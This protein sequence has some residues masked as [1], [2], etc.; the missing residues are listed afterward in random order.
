M[1]MSILAEPFGDT[2]FDTLI[3]GGGT[4]IEPSTPGLIEF[5]R[6]ALGRNRRGAATWTRAFILAA[7][8]LLDGRRANTHLFYAR[9]LHAQVPQVKEEAK[10]ILIADDPGSAS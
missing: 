2:N 5:V 10:R 3:I 6:Q 9:D 7:T 4:V 1:G 8:G